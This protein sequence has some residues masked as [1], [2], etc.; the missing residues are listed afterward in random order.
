LSY[1][2]FALKRGVRILLPLVASIMVG[3]LVNHIV[4]EPFNVWQT[5]ANLLSLQYVWADPLPNM[6]ILWTMVYI[7]WFYVLVYAVIL[8]TQPT[9]RL[10]CAGILVL[11]MAVSVYTVAERGTGTHFLFVF[12]FGILAYYLKS[13]R[14]PKVVT[15]LCLVLMLGLS[16]L[17][18]VSKPSISHA[19]LALNVNLLY[20]LE[21]LCIALLVSQF[22]QHKP[23]TRFARYIEQK[24]SWFAAFSYSLYLMHLPVITL[25]L[26]LGFPRAYDVN[27]T[28]VALWLGGVVICYIVSYMFYLAVEKPSLTWKKRLTAH[29]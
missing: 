29:D 24:S 10:K 2:E 21:S 5:L 7:V 12:V 9:A 28:S 6:P 26:Y 17:A 19:T 14:L 20:T 22:I 25:L 27:V 23:V 3:L 4:G 1:S 16:L 11:A 18:K 8:L 15:I 13:F